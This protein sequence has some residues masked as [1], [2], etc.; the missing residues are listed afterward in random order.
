VIVDS[1]AILA[2]ILLE[3]DEPLML[4]TILASK[5]SRMSAASWLETSIV[6]DGKKNARAAARFEEVIS[7][8]AIEIVAVSPEQAVLARRAHQ[9]YG[10]GQHPA[11]LNY[12]DCFSYALAKSTGEPLL[13]KGGDFS[14]TDIEP[15]LRD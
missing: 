14:Q 8:L 15:A 9:L 2:I 4:T 6:V 7:R 5:V 13:F 10:R 11:R 12:G 1:S 3:P